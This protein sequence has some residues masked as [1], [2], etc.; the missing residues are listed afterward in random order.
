[1]GKMVMSYPDA[2]V[3]MNDR[4]VITFTSITAGHNPV[5]A[6]L[7]FT[8]GLD[9][10]QLS[11]NSEQTFMSFDL[12]SVIKKL[13]Q[14]NSVTITVSGI[15][16]C[17]DTSANIAAF[18]MDVSSGRTLH[19]R[20]HNAERVIYYYDYSELYDIEI[21]SLEGGTLG[22]FPLSAGV[23]KINIGYHTG[24][25][26]MTVTD[27]EASRTVTFKEVAAGGDKSVIGAQCDNDENSTAGYIEVKYTNTDGCHRYL[28]G[29]VLSRKRSIEQMDWRANELVRNTPNSILTGHTDEITLGFPSVERLTYSEDI[30]YS[31]DTMYK[32][33]DGNWTPCTIANK[34]LDLKNWDKNDI[35]ITIR[36]LA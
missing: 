7:S 6:T 12:Y 30:M 14:G 9:T 23:N 20:S 26:S 21:L 5:G 29:K 27:G 24:D 10:V 2:V 28:K 25:F 32:N 36:T 33:A 35:E 19:S 15:V 31:H 11:Y 1:M 17:G 3:F 18:T 4:N 16:S 34:S 8:N 22:V 13:D